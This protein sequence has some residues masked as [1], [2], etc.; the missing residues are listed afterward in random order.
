MCQNIGV[1]EEK[2]LM[3]IWHALLTCMIA[4]VFCVPSILIR[5]AQSL[6]ELCT[7]LC[8]QPAFLPKKA[9]NTDHFTYFKTHL[10]AYSCAIFTKGSNPEFMFLDTSIPY[11]KH[12]PIH[13]AT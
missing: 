10:N 8:S 7:K 3:Q 4:L 5:V 12:N 13:I 11:Y 9:Y 2:Y 6:K 1:W